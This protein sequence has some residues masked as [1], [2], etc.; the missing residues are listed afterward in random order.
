MKPTISVPKAPNNRPE[1]LN[2]IGIARM[3][4]PNE[5]FKRCAKV[6]IVLQLRKF[7][8]QIHRKS[9]EVIAKKIEL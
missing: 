5:L 3:P 8:K 2:A 1:F 7:W 9:T 4:E 6:P